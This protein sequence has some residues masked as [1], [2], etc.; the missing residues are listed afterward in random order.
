MTLG[1]AKK[2]GLSGAKHLTGFW[3]RGSIPPKPNTVKVKVKRSFRPFRTR[4]GVQPSPLF[5]TV[6]FTGER[7]I[8]YRIFL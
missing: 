2:G 5:V 1:I 3:L 7:F 4:V 6:N 8:P